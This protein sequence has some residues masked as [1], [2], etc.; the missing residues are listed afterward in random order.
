MK[1]IKTLVRRRDAN[2]AFN[3]LFINSFIFVMLQHTPKYTPNLH[4][5]KF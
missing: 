5:S 3:M 1:N 4:K 2:W